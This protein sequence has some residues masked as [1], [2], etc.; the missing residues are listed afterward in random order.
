[1]KS[2]GG[3]A[4]RDVSPCM[5]LLKSKFQSLHIQLSEAIEEAEKARTIPVQHSGQ[6]GESKRH[7]L[8]SAMQKIRSLE[9]QNAQL[10]YSEQAKSEELKY[11][12]SKDEIPP[13]DKASRLSKHVSRLKNHIFFLSSNR[14][15]IS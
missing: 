4:Q 8:E 10:I 3:F 7:E 13:A 6:E 5:Y 14:S 1:M 11:F 9:A 2:T 12:R 15:Y